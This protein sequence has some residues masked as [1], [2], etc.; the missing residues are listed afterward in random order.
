MQDNVIIFGLHS[1]LWYL[2]CCCTH[3]YPNKVKAL[4]PMTAAE[5]VS[6]FHLSV[7]DIRVFV[8]LYTVCTAACDIEM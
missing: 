7:K 8:I 1:M 5:L 4:L 2:R 3:W 6:M